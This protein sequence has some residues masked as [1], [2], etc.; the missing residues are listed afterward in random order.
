MRCDFLYCTNLEK[1]TPTDDIHLFSF[2]LPGKV[3]H[4]AITADANLPAAAV[5][6]NVQVFILFV[7]T[8]LITAPTEARHLVQVAETVVSLIEI[9]AHLFTLSS[10]IF[11]SG[12]H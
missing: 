7:H 1:K 11:L 2:R 4:F 8:T 5:V 3:G 10:G 12:I 6:V 9:A